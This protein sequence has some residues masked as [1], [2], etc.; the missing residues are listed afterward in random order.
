MSP[1][2]KAE[3]I[4]RHFR[5]QCG[6]VFQTGQIKAARAYIAQ[7]SNDIPLLHGDFMKEKEKEWYKYTSYWYAVL[8]AL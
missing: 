3:E 7:L 2:K 8:K 1:Y 5:I 6:L 4:K